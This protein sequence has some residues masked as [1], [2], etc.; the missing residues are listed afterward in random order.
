MENEEFCDSLARS[1][2]TQSKAMAAPAASLLSLR[3]PSSP[4]KL[5]GK[6]DRPKACNF[7]CLKLHSNKKRPLVI[8]NQ[9][10][11]AAASVVTKSPGTRNLYLV[12]VFEKG[13]RVDKCL[14]TAVS[15]ICVELLEEVLM[16]NDSL[17]TLEE[18]G[19]INPSGRERTLPL[20]IFALVFR[21]SRYS[22][23]LV[24]NEVQRS[25]NNS[26]ILFLMMPPKNTLLRNE[27][28]PPHLNQPQLESFVLGFVCFDQQLPSLSL[29]SP[30]AKI[31]SRF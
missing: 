13:L 25:G 9:A 28:Q 17:E 4:F 26:C 2:S 24:F 8:I 6:L 14:C 11:A 30:V 29:D 31:L 20:K 7:T 21:A 10:A 16:H 22:L 5:T 12:L 18:K 23:H 15:L 1:S 27:L 19:L 3:C